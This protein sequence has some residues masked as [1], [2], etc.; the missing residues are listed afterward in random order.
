[1]A[2]KKAITVSG[3][4]FVSGVDIVVKTGNAIATTPPLYIKVESVSGD[5]AN[6]KASVTFTDETTNEQ[7]VRKDY[8]FVPNMDGGNFIAQAYNYLKTL[9]DFA[10]AVDC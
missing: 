2:I 3:I 5:K 6:I 1:M 10:G 4:G 9:P 8:S 7:L